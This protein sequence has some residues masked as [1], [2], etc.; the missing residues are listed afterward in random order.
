MAE[1]RR[2]SEE[3]LSDEVRA[4][5]ANVADTG[6]LPS[7]EDLD[8]LQP[9]A[10]LVKL[11]HERRVADWNRRWERSTIIGVPVAVGLIV[12]WL[13]TWGPPTTDID[14]EAH[15]TSV[16]FQV[17][18]EQQL[19]EGVALARLTVGN[20]RCVSNGTAVV[21]DCSARSSDQ[22]TF[23]R[24]ATSGARQS[25]NVASLYVPA[26]SRV[27]I[28]KRLDRAS[29]QVV[30]EPPHGST[31]PPLVVTARGVTISP[32]HGNRSAGQRIPERRAAEIRRLV[33]AAPVKLGVEPRTG[34]R[35][36]LGTP[37]RVSQ[38]GLAEERELYENDRHQVE[39]V[40]S[41]LSGTVVLNALD[42]RRVQLVRYDG[43]KFAESRGELRTL[44]ADR[45]GEGTALLLR[46]HGN[47]KG[48]TRGTLSEPTTLM[49]NV[50]E[51]VM[52]NRNVSL[53]RAAL[54]FLIVTVL[55]ALG[56]LGIRRLSV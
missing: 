17:E 39:T 20:V 51:Y 53:A 37:F 36:A 23:E 14:L 32:L 45:T 52:E 46:Y 6:R 41:V 30:I 44:A 56:M 47:V 34:A 5:S 8:A 22:M 15:L 43:L 21:D 3:L 16:S 4:L 50:L 29:Y 31:P 28:E 38:I 26:H 48:M 7:A 42:G 54:A 35:M 18:E 2:S 11:E 55:T 1:R 40:S 27:T 19:L 10:T 33:L 25:L 24:E 12:A 13:L 49:P 9:L